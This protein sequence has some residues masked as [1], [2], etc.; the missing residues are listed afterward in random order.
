MSHIKI[1]EFKKCFAT[2]LL[3]GHD[4]PK[5]QKNLHI[6][7]ISSILNLESNRQYAENELNNELQKWTNCF[8]NDFGLDHVTLR[9]Y[10]VDAHYLKRDP[11][12][13]YYELQTTDLPYTFD[14]E[15]QELNLEELVREE[16]KVR[17]L[18]KQQYMQ[19][20]GKYDII[21]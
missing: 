18:K 8:G 13:E 11:A 9:R 15:I 16:K 14:P 4:L 21:N 12:G 3:G 5:K 6:L 10:L 17:E 1:S 2:L 7:L 20:T 19:K